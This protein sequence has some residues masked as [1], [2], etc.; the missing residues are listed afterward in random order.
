MGNKDGYFGAWMFSIYAKQEL[1]SLDQ[2]KSAIGNT[3]SFRMDQL[4]SV[5]HKLY[6]LLQDL[7]QKGYLDS[8]VASLDLDQGGQHL[9]PNAQA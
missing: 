7:V 3:G 4:D 6:A 9:P 2:I 8:E 5:L 1:D